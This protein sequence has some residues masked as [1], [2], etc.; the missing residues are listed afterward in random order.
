[1][2]RVSFIINLLHNFI[3]Y[4]IHAKMKTL[5]IVRHAKSSWD[6]AYM[7]DFDRPLNNRGNNNAPEMGKR[8]ASMNILPDLIISSS[9]NR[10]I[11][12]AKKIAREINYNQDNIKETKELY[13]AS[14]GTTISIIRQVDDQHNSLMIFGHNPGWTDL[15]NYLSNAYID[16]I[17]TCGIAAIEFDI[18]RWSEVDKDK[19]KLIFFDYPKNLNQAT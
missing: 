10:A 12:T 17:P 3:F 13:L 8:L 7:R 1:M 15:T 11:T 6:D 4:S 18:E 16:N 9:A 19:G 2:L 5:Y 14:I